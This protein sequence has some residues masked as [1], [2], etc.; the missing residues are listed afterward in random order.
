MQPFPALRLALLNAWIKFYQLA[1][2]QN[3]AAY[4]EEEADEL[5][6]EYAT[7]RADVP[8]AQIN[9]ELEAIR[10]EAQRMAGQQD[11]PAP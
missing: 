8:Y 11:P 5:A 9:A 2:V 7:S 1:D 4:F 10:Q 3:A 6:I